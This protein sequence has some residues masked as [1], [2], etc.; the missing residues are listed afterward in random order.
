MKKLLLILLPLA[1][2]NA[3]SLKNLIEFATSNNQL[4]ISKEYSQKSKQKELDSK[5]S[6]YYPTVDVGAYYNSVDERDLMR[7]GSTYS[8]FAKLAYDIYDG[9]SRSS[10]VT[11]KEQE[12]QAS[13]FD[14]K[15]LKNSIALS[16]VEHFFNIKSLEATLASRVDAQKSLKVQLNRMSAF[17]DAHLATK[18]DLD[19]LQASYDTN[20]YNMESI[21]LQ[22]LTLKLK[23]SLFV[24]KQIVTLDTSKFNENLQREFELID[25]INSLK[26]SKKALKS[27]S[28]SVDSIYYPQLRI[29]DTYSLYGYGDTDFF[30]PEGVDK[31]NKIML[32]ANFRLYDN[33]AIAN[34]KQAIAINS[35][36]LGEQIKYKTLEQ[37]MNYKLAIATIETSKIKIKSAL[38]ALVSASSAF[39]TIE[40]KY[41]AG[42]VD[43]VVYLNALV[44]KTNALSLY[45]TS[46]NDLQIAYA[47]YYYFTGKQIEEFLSE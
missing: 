12:F 37:K 4:I 29:E 9:G 30:H 43:Y 19:R 40:K 32:T 28:E 25:S 2:L 36:A 1:L 33:S 13:S 10:L 20:I 3:E 15:D 34:S 47:R 35:Q 31:Q 18:D 22:I 7:P 17:Y 45:E 46:L 6:A 8:G 11:Q 39:R 23:L 42:I 24:G 26:S 14:V 16:I 38:S 21:K 44:S 5:K 41:N 27:F